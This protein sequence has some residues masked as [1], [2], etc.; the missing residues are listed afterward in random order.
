MSNFKSCFT[1]IKQIKPHPNKEVERLE[2]AL[3]YDFEVVVKKDSMKVGDVV[4]FTPVDSVLSPELESLVFPPDSKIKLHNSRVRQIRIKQFPSQGL[5]IDTE[6]INKV[7]SD[8]GFKSKFPLE[9]DISS[10]VGISKYVEPVKTHQGLPITSKK[11]LAEHPSFHKYNGLVNLKWGD[12]F[13][14]GS[15]QVQIQLKMHGSNCRASILPRKPNNLWDRVLKMFNLLPRYQFRYGSN[16]VDIT[17]K[18]NKN[19]GFYSEDVYG[20]ALKAGN[21]ESKLK[22]NELI[23]GEVVGKGIQKNYNYGHDSPH[24]ILFDVKVFDSDKDTKGRWLSP[25]EVEA[26]SKERGIP[27]VPILYQGTYSREI[28]DS[29]ISGEDPYYPQHKVRE[30]VVVKSMDN[31]NDPLSEGSKKARKM[32]NPEYL[33]DKSNTDFN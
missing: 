30:G 19:S 22:P 7:L 6:L 9:K 18:D 10:I 14:S 26:F 2:I 20:K 25:Q 32:I 13:E 11:R 23:Y 3:V 15:E 17:L 1:T 31:Y 33:D 4:F 28:A 29:L 24:F 5:L 27:M 16:N 12:P 8:K 21:I